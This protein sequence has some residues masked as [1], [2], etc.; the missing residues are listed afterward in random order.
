MNKKHLILI[1]IFLVLG[2]GVLFVLQI[3]TT[4]DLIRLDNSIK[5]E[6]VNKV[7]IDVVDAFRKDRTG[8]FATL[9]NS[10][11]Y[12]SINEV[13]EEERANIDSIMENAFSLINLQ[14]NVEYAFCCRYKNSIL[15]ERHPGCYTEELRNSSMRYNLSEVGPLIT[16][17][18]QIVIYFP[19]DNKSLLRRGKDIWNS[20]I[21]DGF[22][23]QLILMALY[24][25]VF[26]VIIFLWV[27]R[28]FVTQ[29]QKLFIHRVAHEFNTPLATISLATEVL[30]D[31]DI[32]VN[33]EIMENY[34]KVI[35]DEAKFMK[36]LTDQVLM[37]GTLANNPPMLSLE[38][39]DVH[40]Y[41]DNCVKSRE[42]IINERKGKIDVTFGAKN[43]V[44]HGNMTV[45]TVFSNIID[46]AIKY[47]PDAPI[48]TIKTD[49]YGSNK[50][51]II[52]SDKGIGMSEK[53]VRH[54]FKKYFRG[55]RLNVKGVGLGLYNAYIVVT[56]MHGSIR[57]KSTVGEGTTI[58]I[59]LPCK[60]DK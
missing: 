33:E 35:S 17:N 30:R 49:N 7:M 25:I 11:K 48:I 40:Q 56:K 32:A 58:I 14:S 51:R 59:T 16:D 4:R 9:L 41:I 37:A 43:H 52:V 6:N 23:V 34:L 47:S 45:G 39:I 8:D 12:N 21:R 10:G 19:A 28:Y 60:S 27:R 18:L 54:A 36:T 22:A 26:A 42:L 3:R 38:D 44:V 55:D 5:S 29:E 13:F 2:F 15:F 53:E 20:D 57:I 24:L 31:R 46:N 50:V 1:I